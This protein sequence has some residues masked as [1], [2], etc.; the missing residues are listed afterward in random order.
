MRQY[1]YIILG[2]GVS[3]LGFAKRVTDAGKSVLVLE[4]EAVVGGLSR[5]LL[6][7]GFYLDFC[8]HRFHTKNKAL[9]E[10]IKALPGLTLHTHIK[11]SR[12]FMFGKWL[13]YP[14]EIEALLRAMPLRQSI[15]AAFSFLRVRLAKWLS[16]FSKKVA[17]HC[18]M[19][20]LK[21]ENGEF[22]I[23]K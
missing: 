5:T 13:K 4:K 1:D 12:I 11:R 18:L 21:A 14:F 23:Q 22:E 3:G 16:I 17:N 20:E 19:W 8:A 6:H 7:D 10:E 15:P 2:G 9:L